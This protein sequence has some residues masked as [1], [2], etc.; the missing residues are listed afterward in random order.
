L[1]K[2]GLEPGGAFFIVLYRRGGKRVVFG[3]LAFFE[4]FEGFLEGSFE[5]LVM[6]VWIKVLRGWLW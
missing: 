3:G 1:N 2:E 5:G 4:V 6:V